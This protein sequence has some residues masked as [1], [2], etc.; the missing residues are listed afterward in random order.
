MRTFPRLAAA[1]V[2]F[3]L[4]AFACGTAGAALQ[5]GS[6]EDTFSGSY[7]A[8]R[9]ADQERDINAAITFYRDALTF[10]PTDAVLNE[11]LMLLT[12]A[13]GDIPGAAAL[14]KKVIALADDDP[15]ARLILAV[16]AYKGGRAA[17]ALGELD[18]IAPSE[19]STITAGLFR[20]WIQF[21]QHDTD[22]AVKTIAALNG[23]DWYAVFKDF[24]T[25]L[26]L[27]AAGRSGD[28][29][30]PIKRAYAADA[31]V[32]GIV[33]AYAR[34]MARAGQRDE[35]IRALIALSGDNPHTPLVRDLLT[36]LKGGAT[37]G[38]Q[39]A[40][41]S[42]GVAETF[43]DLGLI[44]GTDD[45][46][47][48]PASYL[49][50]ANYL[51]VGQYLATIAIGD[52]FE[53]VGRCDEALKLYQSVPASAV[54]WRDAALEAGACLAKTGSIADGAKLVQRVV[55]ADATDIDAVTQLGD[56]YR[57]QKDMQAAVTAYSRGIDAVHDPATAGWGIYFNRAI[58]Y[59][60]LNQWPQ[61]ESDLKQSLA[62]NPDQPEV[63]NYLGYTWV[64]RNE[65][66]EQ[67]LDMIKKA[68]SLQ[69]NDGLIIDSLGWAYHKLGRN[70]DAVTE[71][72]S[73]VEQAAGDPIVND[74]LGDVYWSVGRKR[75]AYYQW[76][77]ARDSNPDP[78]DLPRILAKLQ[79]G[80]D[81]NGNVAAPPSASGGAGA[82]P[83]TPATPAPN[84]PIAPGTSGEAT[85]PATPT[86]IT[87]GRGDSLSSIAK[88]LFGDPDAY[89]RL[90]RANRGAI[91]NPDIIYPGMQLT[92]PGTAASK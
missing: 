15:P 20:A 84:P 8:G 91:T 59:T 16:D 45:G 68:V 67:A 50:L 46:P 69:P 87:V 44:I 74:H 71:M 83:A 19:L 81:A 80:L 92:L 55:D 25:A 76:A 63:L 57:A 22:G 39:I 47:E 27:D 79:Y 36:Q 21:G 4:S 34:I 1:I 10:Q 90:Y 88:R 29:V 53:T 42:A 51:D 28:A 5:H 73:A 18:K 78:A 31:T 62:L 40:S 41:A 66:L 56:L 7:L 48:L 70:D 86:S 82:A 33:V 23:P 35:A 43:L 26:V 77:H 58:A 13:K 60:A 24:Q 49:R 2:A 64:D 6:D 61:A 37:L 89:Y 85:P 12:L 3:G 9:S 11:R 38:P 52:V 32:R 75:E 65:N 14:A 72:E 54:M 30:A 17:D